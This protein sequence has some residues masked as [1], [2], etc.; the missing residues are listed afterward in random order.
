[1]TRPATSASR[2]TRARV[3]G[4]R[5]RL[6]RI[7]VL[8]PRTGYTTVC[9]GYIGETGRL[10]FARFLEHSYGSDD[11]PGKEWAD[12]IVGPPVEDP[13][14]FASKAEVLAAEEAAVRAELP[15]YN[16]EYNG[17]NPHRIPPWDQQ[18]QRAARDADPRW[19]PA[20]AGSPHVVPGPAR[21]SRRP[22][23]VGK[24]ASRRSPQRPARPQPQRAARRAGWWVLAWLLVAV[25]LSV[26]A[27][28]AHDMAPGDWAIVGVGG[29]S[30]AIGGAL[31]ARSRR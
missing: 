21:T 8:D 23:T 3:G 5:C 28:T 1:V 15:L 24:P 19:R 12:T 2:G 18:A 29:A 6:Y 9:L 27:A 10:T 26:W 14:V 20:P 31:K 16:G 22:R 30:L 11:T 13:R 25:A 4:R 7:Y 17:D